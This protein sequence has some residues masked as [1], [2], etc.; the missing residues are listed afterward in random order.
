MVNILLYGQIQISLSKPVPS[1][2]LSLSLFSKKA[3]F[4][5]LHFFRQKKRKKG[6]LRFFSVC[7]YESVGVYVRRGANSKFRVSDWSRA[8]LTR[9]Y[10]FSIIF[11]SVFYWFFCRSRKVPQKCRFSV[12]KV[13]LQFGSLF[14]QSAP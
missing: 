7:V 1:L 9:Q 10:F 4:I 3:F 11:S 8:Q 5:W 14:P 13:K 6:S 2:D 12:I